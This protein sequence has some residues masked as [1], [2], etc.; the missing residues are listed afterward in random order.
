D[1]WQVRKCRGG[2]VPSQPLRLAH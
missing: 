2:Q 1:A